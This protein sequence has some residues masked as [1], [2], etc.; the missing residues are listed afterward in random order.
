MLT[1]QSR[2]KTESNGDKEKGI[3]SSNRFATQLLYVKDRELAR[4]TTTIREVDG[5]L[6]ATVQVAFKGDKHHIKRQYVIN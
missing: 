2:I 6:M 1:E 3:V 4:T 5:R